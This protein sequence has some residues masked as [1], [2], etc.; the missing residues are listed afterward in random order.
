MT[1]QDYKQLLAELGLTQAEAAKFC[2]V[3]ERTV[4]WWVRYQPPPAA[5]RLFEVMYFFSLSIADIE[6]RGSYGRHK[7]RR[8][9]PDTIHK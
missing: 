3:S 7:S 6:E 2:S 1:G 8:R 9:T 5:A 4:R